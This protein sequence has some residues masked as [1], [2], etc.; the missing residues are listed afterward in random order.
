M[1]A[2]HSISLVALNLALL[3]AL[4][5][6]AGAATPQQKAEAEAQFNQA[7]TLMDNKEYDKACLLLE[8]SQQLDPAMG[9]QFRLAECY[10]HTGRLASAWQNYR[11]VVR[12]ARMALMPK[13][14]QFA[15]ARV[16]ALAPRLSKLAIRVPEKLA[17]VEGLTVERDEVRLERSE[18]VGAE[19][20]PV[21]AGSHRVKVTMPGKSP[22]STEV[23]VGAEGETVRVE[24]PPLLSD[25]TSSGTGQTIAGVVVAGVGVA[26]I[27]AGVVLGV[28]ARSD[29][30]A[31]DEHCSNNLCKQPGFDARN[32][33]R[34]QGDVA[35]GI[36]IA[37]AAMATAGVIVW[38]TA[39]SGEAADSEQAHTS[40]RIDVSP[41]G[42]RARLTW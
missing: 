16:K 35:T 36:F 12:A 38:L 1:K 26:A 17:A 34:T 30:M 37:G 22:W 24:V 27:G 32:S 8:K 2:L 29:Y 23:Q 28:L 33:A 7:L 11:E 6:P 41:M 15:D 14:E 10:E 39:P 5:R 31:V 40:L 20:I 18:W 42:L 13:R 3:I 19:A 4:A 9:T 21:D 25:D